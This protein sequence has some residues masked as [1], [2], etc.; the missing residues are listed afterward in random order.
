MATPP[1]GTG[2]AWLTRL[3]PLLSDDPDAAPILVDL[4]RIL[5]DTRPN[6]V[7]YGDYNAGKSSF[8]RQLAFDDGNASRKGCASAPL[9]RQMRSRRTNGQ[10]F[11]LSTRPAC[12][13]VTRARRRA[14]QVALPSAALILHMLGASTIVATAQAST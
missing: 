5:A 2:R 1:A 3:S 9:P 13:A 14:A 10:T 8:V 12:R 4:Y 7:I 6:V 11:G